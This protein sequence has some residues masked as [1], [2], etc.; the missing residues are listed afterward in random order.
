MTDHPAPPNPLPAELPQKIAAAPSEPG[1]YVM[2]D[3]QG[4]ILYVGK[5]RNLRKRLAA[6]FKP[7]GHGDS[8]VDALVRRIADVETI[9]TRTEKE[10]LILESNLIKRHRPRYNVVLKDDKRYPSLRIDPTEAYPA[11]AVVRKIG[12]DQALYF[13]PFAS[14]HAVRETLQILNKTFKLRQCKKS[15]FR[16]RTRPCLQC[17]MNGCLAPCCREVPAE[18][19]RDQVLEAILFLRGRTQELIRKIRGEMDQAAGSQEYEKAARL[20]DKLFALQRTTEKQIAVTTDFQDRDVFAAASAQGAVVITHLTVRGGFL[21]GTRHFSFPETMATAD[22]LLGLFIRQF[23]EDRAAVPGQILISHPLEDAALTEEWLAATRGQKVR[24][25]RP[26]RGEKARLLEMAIHNAET[27]LQNVIARRSAG[28][29]MLNRLQRRLKLAR[30]PQRIE[31]ADCSTLMGTE[32]VAGMV[33]FIDGR[34]E[35][36]AYRTYRIRGVDL[37]DD[38]AAMAEILQ[39]RLQKAGDDARALPDLLMVDGGRGQLGVALAVIQD[40]RLQ[41]AFDVIGIAKKDEGRGETRDKIYLPGRS[42]PVQ[43]GRDGDLLLFLQRVRDE[44]HRFVIGFHRRRRRAGALTSA[45]DGIRGLGRARRAL[46]MKRFG[47]VEAMRAATL[48]ELSVLPGFNRRLAETLKTAL[49]DRRA[50]A[51]PLRET[52]ESAADGQ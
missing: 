51:P 20:R 24:I 8:K 35:P 11:F 4:A 15:E 5:A 13:G 29:D 36:S 34:A 47:S 6:Y 37:P 44:S 1:V 30:Y 40:L 12:E 28:I 18:V 45:L 22:D 21:T 7:S 33:V 10:A 16:V 26:E 46:L 3:G 43:F 27:E 23:Y 14:A 31:C 49:E 38:Y 25:H 2:R 9:L 48:D 39:R 32:T 50:A 17:Q 19:Y 41:G 52:P 42:N